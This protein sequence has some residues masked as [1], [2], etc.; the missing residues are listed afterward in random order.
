MV[1][2][3]STAYPKAKKDHKCSFCFGIIHS[4]EEYIKESFVFDG[5]FYVWKTHIRCADIAS[6]L[7]MYEEC[8]DEGVTAEDFQE[9]IRCRYYDL[10]K[11][12]DAPFD[13]QLDYVCSHY[14]ST[15]N[16]Q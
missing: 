13:E 7:D 10:K 11:N 5:D 14:L 8:Y 12:N 16:K 1:Q 9:I 3:L 2:I 6:E 4:G 15:K